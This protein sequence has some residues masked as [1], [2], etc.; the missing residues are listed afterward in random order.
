MCGTG[1]PILA[2]KT[3]S[4]AS[5]SYAIYPPRLLFGGPWRRFWMEHGSVAYAHARPFSH[6]LKG[7]QH[8][9]LVHRCGR[10]RHQP[11]G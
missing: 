8:V 2:P 9:Y 4:S 7:K 6:L 11:D 3:Q 5:W 10:D 1:A